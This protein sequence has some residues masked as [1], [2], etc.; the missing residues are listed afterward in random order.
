MEALWSL[1]R[2][3]FSSLA[4]IEDDNKQAGGDCSEGNSLF[5]WWHGRG[6]LQGRPAGSLAASP[7]SVYHHP[8]TRWLPDSLPNDNTRVIQQD[9][10]IR[11]RI[12]EHCVLP[13][14]QVWLHIFG[15]RV[16]CLGKVSGFAYN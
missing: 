4:V 12:S 7:R 6:R 5:L 14:A 15:P 16:V 1:S 11:L 8:K 13:I 10:I 2:D 9:Y 3:L